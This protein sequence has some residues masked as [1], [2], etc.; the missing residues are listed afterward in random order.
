MARGAVEAPRFFL[1]FQS[2]AFVETARIKYAANRIQPQFG[3][4]AFQ[5]PKKPGTIRLADVMLCA[6]RVLVEKNVFRE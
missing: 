5:F 1:A 3:V 4:G 2:C 6:N